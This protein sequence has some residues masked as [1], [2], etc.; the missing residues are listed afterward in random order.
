VG[1]IQERREAKGLLVGVV[2]FRRWRYVRRVLGW[3]VEEQRGAGDAI[4][5]MA[6]G[7]PEASLEDVAVPENVAGSDE[8][9]VAVWLRTTE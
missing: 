4:F 7:A 5:G 9:T 6:D 1:E 3:L 2:V 8:P